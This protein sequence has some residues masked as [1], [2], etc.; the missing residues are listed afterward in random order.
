MELDSYADTC[1][2]GK[3][4]MVIYEHRRRV[5]VTGYDPKAGRNLSRIVSA[6]VAYDDPYSGEMSILIINRAIE[7]PWTTICFVF[8]NVAWVG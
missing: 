8:S 6:A 5:S 2:I 3:N 7:I 1:V 4:A